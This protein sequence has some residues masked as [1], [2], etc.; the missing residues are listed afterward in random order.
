M[1]RYGKTQGEEGLKS[2]R[3]VG[4][5]LIY[6]INGSGNVTKKVYKGK[7]IGERNTTERER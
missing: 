1:V 2:K 6:G 3:C 7:I 5:G 4:V